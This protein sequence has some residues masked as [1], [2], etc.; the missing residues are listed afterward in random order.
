MT[1]HPWRPTRRRLA[2][3][4]MAALAPVVNPETTRHGQPRCDGI[5]VV[6]AQERTNGG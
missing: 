4:L 2:D 1:V 5:T 3:A 6:T